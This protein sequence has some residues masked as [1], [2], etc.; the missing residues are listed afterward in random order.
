MAKK[1]AVISSGPG[2]DRDGARFFISALG[3][4]N[5]MASRATRRSA[6]SNPRP[7]LTVIYSMVEDV[8]FVPEAPRGSWSRADRRMRF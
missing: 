3:A 1:K 6:R 7:A 5:H 8:A 2:F 4:P